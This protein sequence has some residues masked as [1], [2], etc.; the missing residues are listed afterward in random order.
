MR[1]SICLVRK[2]WNLGKHVVLPFVIVLS[3][4]ERCLLKFQLFLSSSC[5]V[6]VVSTVHNDLHEFASMDLFCF[7]Q[8]IRNIETRSYITMKKIT[9]YNKQNSKFRLT[10]SC[11]QFRIYLIEKNVSKIINYR[12]T[13]GVTRNRHCWRNRKTVPLK[14]CLF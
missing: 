5:T 14:S 3:S 6:T 9:E 2:K 8:C 1:A 11:V 12:L 10:E 4:L 7:G 13:T